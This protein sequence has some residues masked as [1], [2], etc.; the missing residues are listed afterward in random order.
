MGGALVLLEHRHPPCRFHCCMKQYDVGFLS[1]A[2]L[3]TTYLNSINLMCLPGG[4][5][6]LGDGVIA[7]NKVGFRAQR[8]WCLSPGQNLHQEGRRFL[9]WT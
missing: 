3:Q 6:G 9:N 4:Y 1:V 7:R 5:L 2:L 8:R